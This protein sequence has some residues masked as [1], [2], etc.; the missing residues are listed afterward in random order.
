[1]SNFEVAGGTRGADRRAGAAPEPWKGRSWNVQEAGTAATVEE[2]W[3]AATGREKEEERKKRRRRGEGE[4]AEGRKASPHFFSP[5]SFSVPARGQGFQF[6]FPTCFPTPGS[7]S[8]RL[9]MV[10][11]RRY[12]LPRAQVSDDK[13]VRR[14][15]TIGCWR[16]LKTGM[17]ERDGWAALEGG[18]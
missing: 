2:S 11:P 9:A 15:K 1:M 18:G 6:H 10:P 14:T 4:K 12:V 8:F 7:N 13:G 5:I 16:R 3:L 17:L